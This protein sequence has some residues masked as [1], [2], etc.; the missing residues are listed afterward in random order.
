MTLRDELLALAHDKDERLIPIINE[1]VDLRDRFAELT[2]YESANEA[3]SW[4]V[5]AI[6]DTERRREAAIVARRMRLLSRIAF[7]RLG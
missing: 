2:D 6:E 7:S 4:Y 3:M 1:Y 5:I